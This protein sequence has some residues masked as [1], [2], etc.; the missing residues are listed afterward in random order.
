MV[1]TI[2]TLGLG[3]GLDLQDILD[4]MREIDEGPI[5][6][7]RTKKGRLETQLTEFDEINQSIL[8]IKSHAREL[9]FASTFLARSV[10]VGNDDVLNAKVS[11]GATVGSKQ[12]TVNSLAS[13][14]SWQA[15]RGVESKTTVINSTGLDQTLT[16]RLGEGNPVSII[17]P[18]G[19]TIG[20]LAS[21]INN[22][23]DN[24]GIAA[25]IIDDGSEGTPY[26]LALQSDKSGESNRIRID[27]QIDGYRLDDLQPVK[28]SWNGAGVENPG[29]GIA[30]DNDTFSYRV[31]NGDL[32]TLNGT[33]GATL[34]QIA[35]LINND[36]NNP[37]VTATVINDGS[38]IVPYG[39]ILESDVENES[40]RIVV[41]DN[42]SGY[43]LT[44][45]HGADEASL[46][47]KLDTEIVVDS[48]TY[49]REHSTNITDILSGVTLDLKETGVTSLEVK[50]NSDPVREHIINLVEAFNTTIEKLRED[51]GYDKDGEKNIL[52]EVGSARNLIYRLQDLVSTQMKTQGTIRSLF[53]LGISIERDGT[54]TVDETKLDSILADS[55]DNIKEFFQGDGTTVFTGFADIVNDTL[56]QLSGPATG[57]MATEKTSAQQRIN[58][59]DRQIEND[60]ER[61][62]R[63]YEILAQQFIQ[64]DSFMR[65]MQSMSSYLT[66]QFEALSGDRNK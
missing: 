42:L 43:K 9:G 55:P 47:P 39:L 21:L 38:A 27:A 29:D 17:V 45:H 49:H 65:N 48:I 31:G 40:G 64:L 3:S 11:D 26:Y 50:S 5:E 57:I 20:D 6:R 2:S 41:E 52:T 4:Q 61:L 62:D 22:A 58:R 35:E 23:D 16:F 8:N 53:D 34:Y 18:D 28:S 60:V 15:S 25:N 46:G 59:L 30:D 66:I 54:I 37:G 51:T 19:T 1:G 7:L 10:T 56:G 44:E 33:D 36:V 32:V 63:R 24:P 13:I 12:I 14:S